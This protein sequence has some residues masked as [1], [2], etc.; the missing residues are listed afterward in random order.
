[1]EPVSHY[2]YSDRLKLHF[3]DWGQDGKPALVLI[4]GG[5][6]HARNWDWVAHA[7]R[8]QFHVYAVDL[9]GHGDSAW[10]PGAMYSIAEYI[11]DLSA[12][13]DVIADFPVTLIGHSLGGVIAL[14]YSGIYPDRVSKVV[15]IEGHGLPLT[16]RAH[17]PLPERLRAWI[18]GIRQTERREAHTYPDLESAVRRMKEAN[19]HLNEEVARHLTLHGTNWTADGALVWKFD[20]FVRTLPPYGHSVEDFC[21]IF[22]GVTCPVLLFWGMESRMPDP[23]TDCRARRI[24]NRLI[25]K[26]PGAGHWIHHDRLD[27]FLAETMRF[28]AEK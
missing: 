24:Q 9:R 14:L 22:G 19:P 2:Y 27:L 15:A 10:A 6:D 16:H 25:V 4:H 7:L 5:L 18:E 21:A 3:W 13:V 17:N 11:L 26:V 23:E 28:L 20:N 8:E 1:M 12:F